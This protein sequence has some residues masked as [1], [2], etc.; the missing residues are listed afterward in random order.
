M[1]TRLFALAAAITFALCAVAC[2]SG[3]TQTDF[4]QTVSHGA[5]DV[6]SGDIPDGIAYFSDGDYKDVFSEKPDAEITL[7]GGSGVISDTSRGA[8]GDTVTVAA[9]G[10]YRVSGVSEGVTITVNDP[11]ESGNVYLVLDNVTMTNPSAPCIIVE[12][13]EKVIIACTGSN[14]LV[15]SFAEG[16]YDGAVY[17]KDDITFNGDGSL[18]IESA[19]HGI[20]GRDDVKVTGGAISI[21]CGSVGIKANESFRMGGGTVAVDS[22]Q[23]GIRVGNEAGSGYFYLESGALTVSSGRDG[24]QLVSGRENTTGYVLFGGGSA[25]VT[26]INVGSAP[27]EAGISQKGVKSAGVISVKGT[28]LT[29]CSAEDAL[30]SGSDVYISKG[31]VNITSSGD[32]IK[33]VGSVNVSGGT[34]AVCATDDGLDSDGDI[35]ISGGILTVEADDL[36]FD[37][38]GTA[39]VT[40]GTLLA[41]GKALIADTPYVTAQCLARLKISGDKETEI[42]TN[43]GPGFAYTAAKAFECAVYSSPYMAEGCSYTFTA[44]SQSAVMEFPADAGR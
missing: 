25:S 26:A 2:S 31:E 24:I 43:D 42:T 35:I 32:G 12:A 14:R 8:S 38:V 18:T 1:K 29:V 20:V 23:D 9:K 28:S 30:Q 17:A 44:G 13:A 39:R 7:S 10:V 33:A 4:S 37:A 22:G 21:K 40:N 3:G 5:Q 41:L 36:A 27:T 19:L 6:S 16:E 34:I 15:C 11:T